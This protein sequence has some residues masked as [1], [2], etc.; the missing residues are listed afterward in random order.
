VSQT[1]FVD[2]KISHVQIRPHRGFGVERAFDV[3]RL[4]RDHLADAHGQVDQ[5]LAAVQWSPT[6]MLAGSMLGG[7]SA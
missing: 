4:E 3:V 6:Q 7:R 1:A 5:P 2:G